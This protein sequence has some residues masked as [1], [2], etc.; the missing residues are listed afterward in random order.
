LVEETCDHFAVILVL[1]VTALLL[2]GIG[3]LSF[4]VAGA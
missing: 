1:A 2:L 4:I 3:I